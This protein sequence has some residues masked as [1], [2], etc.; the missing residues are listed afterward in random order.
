MRNKSILKKLRGRMLLFGILMG[1]VFPIYANFFVIFKEGY[2]LFFVIGCTGAGITVGI[3]SFYFVKTILLKQLQ[4]VANTSTELK[5]KNLKTTIRIES[6]DMVGEIIEGINNVIL[7]IRGLL[8]NIQAIF[9]SSDKVLQ[10]VNQQTDKEISS[11]TIASAID[12]VVQSTEHISELTASISDILR[13]GQKAIASSQKEMSTITLQIESLV[14]TM[15]SLVTHS[16]AIQ[17]VLNV[18]GE[19]TAQTNLLSLNATI[20]AS[21]AGDS[22]KS[23]MVVASEIRRLS[24]NSANNSGLIREKIE[25]INLAV[26]EASFLVETI[27]SQ[28]TDNQNEE[29]KVEKHFEDIFQITSNFIHSNTELKVSVDTLNSS[30]SQTQQT[31]NDLKTDLSKLKVSIAQYSA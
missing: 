16:T 18:I 23:F 21:K 27:H 24:T 19:M 9:E 13:Q 1:V 25:A 11:T 4:I 6:H 5:K 29:N 20:E 3:V 31:L 17:N 15:N 7:E 26:E 10:N 12:T 2:F 28:I 22:G 8:I 30:F 14:N